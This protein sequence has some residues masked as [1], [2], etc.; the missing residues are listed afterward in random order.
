MDICIAIDM[1]WAPDDSMRGVAEFLLAHRVKSTWFVTHETP[2]LDLLRLDPDLFELGIHP[3]FLP[4]ST[5]GE[6]TEKVL[7]HCMRLVPEAVSVRTHGLMLSSSIL[8][9]MMETTPMRFEASTLLPET[10]LRQ[11]SIYERGGRELARL[12]CGWEDD[13]QFEVRNRDYRVHEAN[14]LVGE[15]V[16]VLAF[17]PIHIAL[18]SFAGQRYMRCKSSHDWGKIDHRGDMSPGAGRCFRDLVVSLAATGR[19]KLIRETGFDK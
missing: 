9:R 18:N 16:A 13:Y 17:H 6:T 8:D 11:P 3:N 2:V 19:H 7:E 12:V 1:D 15:G 10:T 4:R 5:Q 14:W